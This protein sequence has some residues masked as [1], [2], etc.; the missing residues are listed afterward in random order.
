MFFFRI[1]VGK[2]DKRT[3]I[4]KCYCFKYFHDIHIFQKHNI[5]IDIDTK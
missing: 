1:D 2:Y 5:A 4:S 3:T